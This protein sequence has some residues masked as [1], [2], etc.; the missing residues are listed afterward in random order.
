M[1]TSFSLIIGIILLT[2]VGSYQNVDAK[3]GPSDLPCTSPPN[4]N[5]S[6]SDYSATKGSDTYVAIYVLLAISVPT[7]FGLILLVW[8]KRKRK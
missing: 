1:K 3:C 6:G 5:E 4:L 7:G 8:K 2:L